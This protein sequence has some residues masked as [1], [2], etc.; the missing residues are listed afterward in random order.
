MKIF[1]GGSQGIRELP[2]QIK[3][4]LI[5]HINKGD[6]FLVGDCRGADEA[7]QNW[8]MEYSYPQVTVYS[9]DSEVRYNA[10]FPVKQIPTITSPGLSGSWL[11][12]QAKDEGM[13]RDADAGLFL[14]DG[15][16]KG[17]FVNILDLIL[18]GKSME[19]WKTTDGKM[20]NPSSFD[21]V[22][23]MLPAPKPDWIPP[24]KNLAPE[25]VSMILD[26]FMPS[27]EM[28]EH[29]K[30]NPPSRSA[31]LEIILGSPVSLQQKAEVMKSLSEKEDFL[32]DILWNMK[33]GDI[34]HDPSFSCHWITEHSAKKS[35]CDITAALNELN[36]K[37]GEILLMKEAW[38][39]EDLKDE[40]MAGGT[41][42]LSL[43]AAL[44]YLRNQIQTEEW[45]EESLC[46]TVLEKWIPLSDGTFANPYTYYLIND[47]PVYFE[48]NRQYPDDCSWLPES[49]KYSSSS[50]EMDLSTPFHIG[51]IITLDCRPF[52][53]V[54]HALLL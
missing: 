50:K 51:D 45:D 44:H 26:W 25:E 33:Y 54:K 8:L 52:A 14:W 11:F 16:S 27:A 19:V 36:L 29:L 6:E 24:A 20:F 9:S 15:S 7:F 3:N 5:K 10:G 32:H 40:N 17:T 21:D 49:Y 1:L 30:K 23:A 35:F 37:S 13:R 31:L 4:Q 34:S 39:D 38:Y 18:R 43:D 28:R 46:W 47:K 42:F 41:P 53:P 12:W 22:Q 48:K 2:L